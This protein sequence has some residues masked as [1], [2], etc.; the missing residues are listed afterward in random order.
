MRFVK[1]VIVLIIL[2]IIIGVPFTASAIVD[3]LDTSPMSDEE[4]TDLIKQYDIEKLTSYTPLTIKCFDVRDDHMIVM[5]ASVG[6]ET[7]VIVVYDDQGNFQY[8]FEKEVAGAFRVMWSGNDIAY[9]GIRGSRLAIIN[10]SGEV[11]DIRRV[12][13][14][15]ENSVY[16]QKVLLSTTRT[17]D[18][19][20]YRMTNGHPITDAL[21]GSYKKII[22]T[23]EEGTTVIYDATAN[24]RVR[25]VKGLVAFV[26]ISSIFVGGGIWA[27]IRYCDDIR[28]RRQ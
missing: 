4:V 27:I 15:T 13:N 26:V 12:A 3:G 7:A 10:E 24:R 21:S 11:I 22:K 23:D 6:D 25:L 19:C 1:R 28:Q 5:G 8:G 17:V 20:T 18:N 14:T 9:Y 2:I 16:D